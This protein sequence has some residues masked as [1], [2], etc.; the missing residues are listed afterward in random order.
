MIRK[1]FKKK[2]SSPKLDA[3]MH[4]YK[5]PRDLLSLNRKMVSRAMLVGLFI[6][7]IPMPLQMLAVVL[8]SPFFRFNVPIGVSL[9]W[10]T[11]PFTM[12]F[13]YYIEYTT[14][15]ILLMQEGVNNIQM[16]LDWFKDNI[17]DI[18]IPLYTGT[19]FYSLIFSVGGYYLVNWLWI[20]SV[21][22]EKKQ[23]DKKRKE[24]GGP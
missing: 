15:N 16:T 17:T 22:K 10:I 11:N 24:N 6:A 2:K 18:F 9:V 3:V 4:K 1:V 20:L 23:K 12:P 21:G 8:I 13:I 14:G 7:M 19:L 5:I